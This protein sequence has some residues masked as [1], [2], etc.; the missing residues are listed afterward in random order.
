MKIT[1]SYDANGARK[2]LITLSSEEN[3]VIDD[4]ISIIKNRC[5]AAGY[6]EDYENWSTQQWRLLGIMQREGAEAVI[7]FAKTAEILPYKMYTTSRSYA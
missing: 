3:K 5:L 1:T 7:K 2:D 4:A 6:P